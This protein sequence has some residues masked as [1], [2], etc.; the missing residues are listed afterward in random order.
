MTVRPQ[1]LYSV[2]KDVTECVL[3]WGVDHLL[4][5]N[6]HKGND[7]ALDLVGRDVNRKRGIITGAVA[8][9]SCV[10]PAYESELYGEKVDELGHG[11]D[12]VASMA[13]SLYPDDV[14][15]DLAEKME[16]NGDYGPFRFVGPGRLQLEGVPVSFYQ[17]WKEAYPNGVQGDPWLFDRELG[18][19]MSD[20]VVEMLVKIIGA[21]RGLDTRSRFMNG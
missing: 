14:R 3:D 8:P 7:S 4:F 18:K 11:A 12:P 17:Y 10:T 15:M 21:F 6:G 16:L 20:R 9:F 13:S 1:T 2:V 19:K 5:V